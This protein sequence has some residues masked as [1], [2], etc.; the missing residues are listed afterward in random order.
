MAFEL[1]FLWCQRQKFYHY[2][3]EA[4]VTERIIKLTPIH[5]SVIYQI[6]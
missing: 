6:L 1:N 2:A 3:K 4:R 5:A